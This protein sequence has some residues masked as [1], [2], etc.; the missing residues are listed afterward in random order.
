LQSPFSYGKPRKPIIYLNWSLLQL[1]KLPPIPTMQIGIKT[2]AWIDKNLIIR[3]I[4]PFEKNLDYL[5]TKVVNIPSN[6]ADFDMLISVYEGTELKGFVLGIVNIESL[7][8]PMI[9]DLKNQYMLQLSNEDNTVFTSKNWKQ[10]KKAFAVNQSITLQNTA[11]I[12]LSL[13]PTDEHINSRIVSALK[14]LIISLLFSL[15]TI[16]AVNFAQKN[17]KLSRLN[18]SRY[19]NLLEEVELV[20]VKLKHTKRFQS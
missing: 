1:R 11:V 4:V 13:A 7:F 15:I 8:L 16:I 20:A 14:T 19:R 12:N 18:E 2:I 3:S 10:P 9:D 17:N 5:N 6:K